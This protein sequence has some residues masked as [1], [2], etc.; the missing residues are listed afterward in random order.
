MQANYERKKYMSMRVE[1]NIKEYM[2][3]KKKNT[4]VYEGKGS[5]KAYMDRKKRIKEFI[6][7]KKRKR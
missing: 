7:E 1:N 5:I 3:E 2:D 4:L 6:D